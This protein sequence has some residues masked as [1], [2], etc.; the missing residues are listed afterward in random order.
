MSETISLG[1]NRRPIPAPRLLGLSASQD[2]LGQSDCKACPVGTTSL[3]RGAEAPWQPWE[4]WENLWGSG[5]KDSEA[6][7]NHH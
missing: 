6:M 5:V 7:E 4:P 1:E 2:Q 3:G